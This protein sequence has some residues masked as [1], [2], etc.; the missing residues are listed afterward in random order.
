ML[1]GSSLVCW[2]SKKHPTVSRSSSEAE[3]RSMAD[4]TCEIVWLRTLLLSFSVPQEFPTSL[5]CDNVSAIYI[6][7]NPV[8]HERTKHIE[9]DC[10]LVREKL[11]KGIIVTEYVPST[12][13]PVDL[14]TKALGATTLQYLLGKLG[15]LFL[16]SPPNLRGMLSVM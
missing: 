12:D 9:I 11:Q 10:H 15:V 13:Q 3:Y 4:T 7:V 6:S 5:Y 2:K 8:F 16:S 1:L 14:F